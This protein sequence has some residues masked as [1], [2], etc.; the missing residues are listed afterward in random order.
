MGLKFKIEINAKP[1]EVFGYLSDV[2][3]HGEWGNPSAQMTAKKTSEGPIGVGSTFET[4][5]KF[6][7][8]ATGSKVTIREYNPPEKLV[9]AADQRAGSK[10][11]NFVHTFTLTPI[12]N[13]TRVERDI[14]R[15]NAPPVAALGIIFYPAIKSDAMRGL[16]GLKA[17][18][19]SGAR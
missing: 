1:D 10:V 5:Q 19:E 6:A 14:T 18:I 2:T 15:E 13:G 12:A 3:R 4:N 17:K 9:L 8:K 16:R 7:G 11:H